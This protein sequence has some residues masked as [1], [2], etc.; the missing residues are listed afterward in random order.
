MIANSAADADQVTEYGMKTEDASVNLP[1]ASSNLRAN[2]AD[3]AR[4]ASWPFD[5]PEAEEVYYAPE[6]CRLVLRRDM[7]ERLRK[8]YHM[9]PDTD[10]VYGSYHLAPAVYESV[11][12]LEGHVLVCG[13]P[14]SMSIFV[15]TLRPR[16]IER[17]KILPIVFLHPTP[18]AKAVWMQVALYP[19][20][21]LVLGSAH[22]T[23]DLVRAGVLTVCRA[24]ILSA[25]D[26]NG[27]NDSDSLFIYQIIAKVRPGV[28][29]VCEIEDG[30]NVSFLCK[31]QGERHLS[32]GDDF[33]MSLPFAAGAIYANSLQ[34]KMA[35][36]AFYNPNLLRIISELVVGQEEHE[37]LEHHVNPS[38]IILYQVPKHLHGKSY[39]QLLQY[40]SSCMMLPLGL[41]RSRPWGQSAADL[42]YVF[43]NPGP[44]I[45]VHHADM[46]YVLD[47][48]VQTVSE[49]QVTYSEIQV[50]V[51]QAH[52]LHEC[53]VAHGFRFGQSHGDMGLEWQ[54]TVNGCT[55]CTPLPS[56]DDATDDAEREDTSLVFGVPENP[57][58]LTAALA[59]VKRQGQ[60]KVA[61]GQALLTAA[62]LSASGE[63][64]MWV[65]LAAANCTNNQKRRWLGAQPLSV[66]SLSDASADGDGKAGSKSPP[67]RA[68]EFAGVGAGGMAHVRP[69]VASGKGPGVW[70]EV[71]H[72][73]HLGDA[74]LQ[75]V[76][77]LQRKVTVANDVMTAKKEQRQIDVNKARLDADANKAR[78]DAISMYAS[79]LNCITAL[80]NVT[81]TTSASM[82]REQGEML[83][84]DVS[85]DESP[86]AKPGSGR[87]TG[88][89]PDGP[90]RHDTTSHQD[91]EGKGRRK[92]GKGSEKSSASDSPAS[93]QQ[94][95]ANVSTGKPGSDKPGSARRK[96]I[97]T[98][99][100]LL[101]QG[102]DQESRAARLEVV[103]R[104][105]FV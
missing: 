77:R 38:H 58:P 19:E 23:R 64:T 66:Q 71:I 25:N 53:D 100:E 37:Y 78:L 98:T 72:F 46:V 47:S 31:E 39:I 62:C 43:T 6:P 91:Q 68:A 34:D 59:L 55:S 14:A 70:I 84:H 56:E 3:I 63:M 49:V 74:K 57:F 9:R 95:A 10:D 81:S 76:Q 103:P 1:G 24:V 2:S 79:S 67:L 20:V 27:E 85:H 41:Y 29:I 93:S 88:K 22:E 97:S 54:V 15:H 21:Y 12:F 11:E 30:G 104:V 4:E 92:T 80:S 69:F 18:P 33:T 105:P 28:P 17:S 51:K 42:P 99:T 89:A 13:C 50:T 45:L 36:Q 102:L 32:D 16:H 26:D 5:Y 48:K 8:G 40:L 94:H 101:A 65:P 82:S 60:H 83:W 96:A 44:D 90:S 35:V 61:Q 87:H 73:K 7:H 52:N 86:G 75:H